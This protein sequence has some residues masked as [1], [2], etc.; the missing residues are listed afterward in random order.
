[1]KILILS[2]YFWPENFTINELAITL[3]KQ[4]NEVVVATGKPNYPDGNIYN[5]YKAWGS[6][7]ELFDND[8]EVVRIPTYPRS[9]GGA[10]NLIIN[11]IVF[12]VCGIVKFPFLLRKHKFDSILVFA[13]SPNAAIPAIFL[14]WVKKCHL[15]FWI[16]DLWPD[17]LVATG[18]IKNKVVIG[19]VKSVVKWTYKKA[20]TILVQSLA[21]VNPVANLSDASKVIYYP[22]TA[23]VSIS[24]GETEFLISDDFKNLLESYFTVV[25]TGNIGTAQSMQTLIGAAQILENNKNIKFVLVGS[26]SMLEWV[27]VQQQKLKLDNIFIAGRYPISAMDFIFKNSGCLLAMLKS[28]EIFTFT[29]PGKI[30]AYLSSGMPIIASLNGEGARI[31]EASGSGL[32]CASENSTALANCVLKLYETPESERALM[33]ISGKKYYNEHFEINKQ[34]KKLVEILERSKIEEKY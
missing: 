14:K 19:I 20:D 31:V 3:K 11:Y 15:A 30:Q 25:F 16:L 5:G 28:N 7:K 24:Q 4:G 10:I 6:S 27:K 22:N 18:M 2:Q 13:G 8:I 29:I 34:A 21:F 9:T 17:T 1:M 33:G 12:V 32:T 23:N 26:G